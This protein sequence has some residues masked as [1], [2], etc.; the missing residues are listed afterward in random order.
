MTTLAPQPDVRAML[1]EAGSLHSQ[2]IEWRRHL[3]MHP[4]VAFTEHRT[5]AFIAKQLTAIPGI[6][7]SRPTE[8]SVL[9]VLRGA[10]G[11]RVIAVRAD[12]DA[13]P[14]QEENDVEYRSTIAGSMHACGHDGHTAIVLALAPLLARHR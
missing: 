9:G 7:V 3:H 12:I 2:V 11:G 8:T 5:A 10:T 13:L 4:E 6:A 14:I 1:S